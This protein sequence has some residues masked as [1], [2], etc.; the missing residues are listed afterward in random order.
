MNIPSP[1][2]KLPNTRCVETISTQFIINSYK[3]DL[4]V[5]VSRFFNDFDKVQ[6]WE[7]LD[8]GYLFFYPFS[9]SGDEVF[10]DE[11]KIQLPVMYN[12]P[13]Y[14]TWKWEYD[15]CVNFIKETDKVYE[16]GC[17]NGNFLL[18]LKHRGVKEVYG[19]ELNHD[20]VNV[21]INK[22]LNVEYITIQEKAKHVL[23]EYDVVCT[24]QVLEHISEV[25]SFLDASIKILKKGGKLIITVPFNDPY[26][27]KNDKYNTLNMPPH[28]MGL[29]GKS[30]FVSLFRF[31]PM[32][33]E[34]VI[35]EKLPNV[36]YDFERYYTVNKDKN[37]STGKP[38]KHMYDQLYFRWLKMSHTKKNGKNIIAVFKKDEKI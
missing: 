12:A 3:R 36:G 18:K 28:H 1:I 9:I 34:Q 6:I 2:T 13:Y 5:D 16:I 22:G 27:F 15:I 35:I 38:F 20:S 33:L 30:A 19:T 26:L 37:Y 29:W 7:C 23:E 32:K 17:G 11:L 31:F 4:N 8:T 21:A 24:F 10:Y 14:S 25:K